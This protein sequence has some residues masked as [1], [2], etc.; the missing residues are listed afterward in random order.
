M[1]IQEDE[2]EA[3]NIQ[4]QLEDDLFKSNKKS[5][6]KKW[7]VHVASGIQGVFGFYDTFEFWLDGSRK[8]YSIEYVEN[9]FITKLKKLFKKE[10][11]YHKIVCIMKDLK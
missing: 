2:H 4:K 5:C 1:I 3:F 8:R 7:W 10:R 11:G 6:K 9:D